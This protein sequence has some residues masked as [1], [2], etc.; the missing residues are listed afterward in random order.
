MTKK[1][2]FTIFGIFVLS[3]FLWYYFIY[4]P[5]IDELNQINILLTETSQ[6]VSMARNAQI[7]L[8]KIRE[9]FEI[10]QSKLKKERSKF[11][12][13]DELGKVTKA[14]RNLAKK[15]NLKLVDFSPGL[16]N[17]FEEK[18]AKIVPMPL[19]ITLI[20]RYIEIG[21]FI[22]EWETLPFYLIPRELTLEK[23][24]KYGYD[25]QAVIETKLYTWID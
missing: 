25:V 21:K 8:E 14:L 22:E 18:K 2:F 3:I 6:K 15:H 23:V 9:R 20:G 4:L 19:S 5:Q 24:D 1:K 16:K 10:E 7:N 12:R 11:V 17:Y 13:R